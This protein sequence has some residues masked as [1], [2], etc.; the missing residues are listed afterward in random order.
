MLSG[1]FLILP[2]ILSIRP[3]VLPPAVMSELGSLQDRIRPFDTKEA[4]RMVEEELGRPPEDVF[5]EFSEEPVAAAS[6]AQMS[7]CAGCMRWQGSLGAG[8]VSRSAGVVRGVQ[9]RCLQCRQVQLDMPQ[10]ISHPAGLSR[11]GA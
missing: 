7:G 8:E 3:D 9:A 6:L 5:S 1:P 11:P 2:Q 10:C 4:R